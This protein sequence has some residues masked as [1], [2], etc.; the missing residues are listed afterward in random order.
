MRCREEKSHV[1][2]RVDG[3][4]TVAHIYNSST[5]GEGDGAQRMS[6]SSRVAWLKSKV[7]PQNKRKRSKGTRSC[8]LRPGDPAK[9][10]AE[11]HS[12]MSNDE[13]DCLT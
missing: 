11:E 8:G 7:L 9:A 10:C 12:L 13:N 5:L 6:L 1:L 3:A 2:G 4:W